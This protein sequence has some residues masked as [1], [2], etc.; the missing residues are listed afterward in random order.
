LFTCQS[1]CIVL[2]F[3]DIYELQPRDSKPLTAFSMYLSRS[4]ANLVVL[5][6]IFEISTNCLHLHHYPCFNSPSRAILKSFADFLSPD[7]EAWPLCFSRFESP[8][9]V[10]LESYINDGNR[11]PILFAYG[12]CYSLRDCRCGYLPNGMTLPTLHTN[13]LSCIWCSFLKL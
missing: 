3:G 6:F 1:S 11:N 10:F 9:L 12:Q 13:T 8:P 2:H 5:F 7:R 4:P